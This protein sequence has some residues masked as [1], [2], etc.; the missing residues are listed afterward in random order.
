MEKNGVQLGEAQRMKQMLL[1][2]NPDITHEL[3]QNGSVIITDQEN[4]FI[5]V[6]GGMLKADDKVYY[7]VSPLSPIAKA[8]MGKKAGETVTFNTRSFKIVNVY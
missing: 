7:A 8:M 4:Y 6:G 1:S 2:V 5:S 3:V